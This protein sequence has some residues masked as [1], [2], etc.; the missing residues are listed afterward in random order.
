MTSQGTANEPGRRIA[1][2]VAYEGTGYAGFQMQAGAP[3]IQGELETAIAKLTGE[4]ARVRGA[5]RT[6]A[7]AHACG[8]VVDF[9]TNSGHQAAVFVA[10]LNHYLPDAI[11][12]LVASDVPAGFHSR[13]SAT[14]RSYRYCILNRPVPSPLRRR[15]C[16]LEPTP[17]NLPAMRQAANSLLG[18][19]DFRRIA[20]AHPKDRSAARQVH[21][22]EVGR[23]PA[24]PDVI[25]IDCTANGFLRHQIRRVNA[26]LT[27]IGKGRLPIH[28]MADALAGRAQHQRQIRT[29][30]AKGLCLQSVHYPEYDHY[31]QVANYHETH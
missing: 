5:S 7:G 30:P 25:T 8:Q 18:I 2:V 26:V 31:L 19:R 13:H 1:L 3:T 14:R 15:A 21:R 16:H 29:L 10:A 12:I 24:S 20:T 17:L 27:E 6:D 22:W 23:H 28:A 11:R 4:S 9:A